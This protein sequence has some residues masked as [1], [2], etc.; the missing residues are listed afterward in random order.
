MKILY[1]ITKSNWGGAQKYVY[2]LATSFKAKGVDVAVIYG[3][4]GELHT[5]LVDAGVR[6]YPLKSLVRDVSLVKEY[7]V[8][9]ELID[10]IR[11][12]KPDILHLN[13]SKASGIGAFLGRMLGIKCI[14]VTMHG[15]P[16]REDRGFFS[17]M[18]IYLFTWFTCIFAHKVITVSKQDEADVGAMFFI[19]KKV[20]TIYNGIAVDGNIPKRE[21][22]KGRETRIVSI[23]DLTRNKGYLYGL[24]AINILVKKGILIKYTIE[25]E[26]EDRQKIEEYIAIKKLENVV[27]LL[28]RTLTTKDLLHEHDI[29]VLSSVKEGLP[30]VLLEAGKA[31]LPV[32][33]TITGGIPEII[34]HEDTGLLVQ[35]KDPDA[36]SDA[37]ERIILDKKYGKGLGQKLH[38]HIV[39]NFSY[40]KM[41]VETAKVYGWMEK[42]N[43]GEKSAPSLKIERRRKFDE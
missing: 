13:S 8:T 24:E 23:G 30:Y 7:F 3:G 22:E 29:F 18:L 25:G 1:L 27:T 42:K 34:R 11:K 16:F 17:K 26:G 40:S 21:L 36:L 10:L 37:L 35:P 38:S 6:T 39:Q 9:K 15:A 5:K 4:K 32:V 31:M 14:V 2:D 20:V 28:G 33:T 43:G 41:L 12:E 19:K